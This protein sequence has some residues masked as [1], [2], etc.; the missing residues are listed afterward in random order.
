MID[1]NYTIAYTAA[2]N[3]PDPLLGAAVAQQ[4]FFGFLPTFATIRISQKINHF[5][6]KTEQ[7]GGYIRVPSRLR[8]I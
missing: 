1:L 6:S 7:S 2:S 4:D 8:R 3:I 5:S